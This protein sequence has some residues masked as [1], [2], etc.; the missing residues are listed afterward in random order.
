MLSNLGV[1]LRIRFERSGDVADLDEAIDG[2]VQATRSPAASVTT[3]LTAA[4]GWAR[5]TARWREPAVAVEAY[6][7]AIGLVPLLAWRGISGRDQQHLLQTHAASLARDAAACAIAASRPDLAVE[8]LEA[9]R[10]VYWSQLLGTRTD[11]TALALTLAAPDLAGQLQDCRTVL[12]QPTLDGPS[13]LDRAPTVDVRM[14]AAHRFDE[15]VAQVRALPPTDVLP[16]PEQ[17]LAP[18]ALATLLPGPTDGPVAII[19][20]SQWRC[21]ALLLTHHGVTPVPLPELTEQQVIDEANRYL[22]ALHRFEDSRHTSFDRAC[23]EMAITATLEWLWDHITAPI[24]TALGH[25]STPTGQW[26]RLWWCPTGALTVLPVHAAGYHHTRDTVLDRVVSSYTPTLRTLTATRT[27]PESTHPAKILIVTLPTTPDQNPLPGAKAEHDLLTGWF[28]AEAR[29]ILTNTDATRRSVLDYL[30]SHLWLHASCHGTQHLADPTTGGLLPHDWT[31]AGLIAVTDL[32]HPD[33]T[34]GAFAFLSACKTATGGV[35]NLDEAINVAAAMQHA[36]WRHVIGTLWSVWDD[37]ATTIT[38][39]LYPQ[40]LRTGRLD[41]ST[42][43]H[44]LHSTT[45]ALRDADPT[46]PSIWAPFIH[47]GS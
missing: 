45:R 9:G 5:S 29:T 22:N 8:L 12:E 36:G 44:A 40:L 2:W 13:D 47:T 16:H 20:I 15:L 43:A 42:A 19:N 7:E 14:R 28:T 17:F 35:T 4:G 6:T 23:L 39:G 3:R 26:P 46:R 30:G 1:A 38:A 18:P 32:A 21:D 27:Q 11:L 24:L 37:A 41:P 34:G 33:H 31:T 25:T 10:G